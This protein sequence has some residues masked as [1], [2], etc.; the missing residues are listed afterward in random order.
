ML[1]ETITFDTKTI[2]HPNDQDSM[3]TIRRV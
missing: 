2:Y 3:P 1:C